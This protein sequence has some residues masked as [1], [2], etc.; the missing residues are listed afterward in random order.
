MSQEPVVVERADQPYVAIR[1]TVTMAT[2]APTLIPL[3]SELFG[4][5]GS[6]GIAPAGPPFWRYEVIDMAAGLEMAVGIAVAA[7]AEGDGRV[8]AGVLPGGKYAT[9]LHVGEPATLYDAT[10]D[11][12]DWAAR[13]GLTWDSEDTE[14]GERWGC[15]IEEYLTDP[16]EQPDQSQWE[17]RLAFRLA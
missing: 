16:A 17:T 6:R 9:V 5:L 1:A 3:T 2:L 12:L 8:V 13:A 15:R 10:R 7:P 4:W 14:R 11:L